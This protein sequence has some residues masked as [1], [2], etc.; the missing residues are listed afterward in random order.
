[1]V[2]TAVLSFS[3]LILTSDGSVHHQFGTQINGCNVIRSNLNQFRPIRPASTIPSMD[4]LLPVILLPQF[5]CF[6]HTYSTWVI[7]SR[8]GCF[9]ILKNTR[10]FT[11]C[12]LAIYRRAEG[13]SSRPYI[14]SFLQPPTRPGISLLWNLL[15][16]PSNLWLFVVLSMPNF[17][18]RFTST[19][20]IESAIY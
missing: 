10:Y 5:I 2:S 8:D 15:S 11:Y 13:K 4:I 14:L 19:F 12:P 18:Y 6:F 9:F 20:I 3:F 16:E 1:M 17:L 7:S